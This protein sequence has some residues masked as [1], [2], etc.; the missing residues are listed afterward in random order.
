M[1]YLN[2]YRSTGNLNLKELTINIFCEIFL[3]I[4]NSGTSS[5]NFKSVQ[6]CIIVSQTYYHEKEK[7]TDSEGNGNK[8]FMIN[9]MKKW[10]IFKSKNFWKNYL[11]GLIEDERK[12]INPN[13]DKKISTKQTTTA[14]Y[15]SIFTLTKNM[16]DFGL[17]MD[18]IINLT[19]EAFVKYNISDNH[20]KDIINYLIEEL[21]TPI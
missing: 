8:L 13:N 9:Y 20:K 5:N 7:P 15:S 12:K 6:L 17:D 1:Q 19:N 11:D 3:H 14:A 21:Q 2:N 10:S 16:V 4:L 18:F